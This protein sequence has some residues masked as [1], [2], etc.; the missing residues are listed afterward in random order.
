M[1]SYTTV[2]DWFRS[3]GTTILL[4]RISAPQAKY[5]ITYAGL[6]SFGNKKLLAMAR[7]MAGKFNLL[8]LDEPTSG[9]SPPMIHHIANL[10][11][12]MVRERAMTIALIEHNFSFVSE[13]ADSAYFL[14]AGTVHDQGSTADVLG[15][16]ENREILIGL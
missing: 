4:A 9:V 7:L 8:L 15:R 2:S 6:L 13:V 3:V 10:L 16:A 12:A 11:R 14:R 5:R 1:D